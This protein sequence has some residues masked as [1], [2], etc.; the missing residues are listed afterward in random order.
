MTRWQLTR[1]AVEEKSI[2]RREWIANSVAAWRTFDDY[3]ITA[4]V[5]FS[6]F[7]CGYCRNPTVG[8]GIIGAGDRL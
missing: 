4:D 2:L 7:G 1:V 3:R 6:S 5:G 8:G